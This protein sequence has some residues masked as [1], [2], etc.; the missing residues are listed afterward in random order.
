MSETLLEEL[1]R[2]VAWSAADEEA[3]HALHPLVEPHFPDIARRFYDV[4]LSHD[5]ARQSLTGGESQ[6]GHLRV[7]LQRWMGLLL[8]G[9]WDEAYYE[10][11]CHIGRRH[12]RIS[13]PQHYMFGAMNVVRRELNAV[14]DREYLATPEKLAAARQAVGRV[15]DLELA[16][17]LHTYREDLLAQQ[18]RQERLATFGQLVGSIG[19][20][21]RNPLGVIETSLFILRG[22]AGADERVKKHLDRIGDQLGV[23]NGIITN[24][25]DMIRN[26][27]LAKE[28]VRLAEVV[29]GAADS[30]QRPEGVRLAAA[31]LDDLEVEGDPVQLRQVFVNLIHN[32]VQ[33]VAPEGDVRVEAARGEAHVEVRVE[34]TGPGVDVA[35]ARRLFEP[36]ITTKDRG[37]GL[38]LALVKRIVE[39][40]GGEVSYD[41]AP[42][43]GARFTV[44]LPA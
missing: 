19:H 17:M 38:G 5:G 7:T 11:R 3:L 29:Q 1:K 22:R 6:V 13:L 30:V 41:R 21:L 26:R 16:I 42:G 40:H 36:L 18:A 44:R 34:D 33:A 20:D 39:R 24:L 37:I 25:L 32:A 4:I 28:R 14:I 35:T 15:L 8:R 9:P 10:A 23:A 27:P 2:Y 31:H 43:G 12:V